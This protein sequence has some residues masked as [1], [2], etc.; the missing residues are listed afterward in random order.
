MK[1]HSPG[2]DIDALCVVPNYISREDF[3]TKL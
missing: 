2:G 3:F 1:V